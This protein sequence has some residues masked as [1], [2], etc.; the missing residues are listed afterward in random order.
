MNRMEGF[1]YL[2]RITRAALQTFVEHN[3]PLAPVLTTGGARDRQDG[4]RSSRQLLPKRRDQRRA[5]ISHL[6][7]TARN[8]PLPRLL[9]AKRKL[10][11]GA[12]DAANRL[13]RRHRTLEVE[14][15][16]SFEIIVSTEEKARKLAS[17]GKGQRDA[18]RA[19]DTPGPRE[20]DRLPT[21]TSSG[22]GG[23]GMP[24]PLRPRGQCA[25]GTDHGGRFGGRRVRCSSRA[26]RKASRSIRIKLPRF[27][28]NVSNMAGGVPDIAYYH[29]YWKLA[30]DEALVIDATPPECEH[31]NFQLNNYWMESLDY[32]YYPNSREQAHGEVQAGRLGSG[33]GRRGEQKLRQ[34]D[35]YR[36]PRRG[37]DV[38]A[39]GAGERES[40]APD[41]CREA[42]RALM[43]ARV[44]EV[45]RR[46]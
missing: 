37:N 6:G 15:D 19:P 44:A 7:G 5:R 24:T 36:R 9:H 29:S 11:P 8:C 17:H 4:R 38:L 30:P 39:L 32:R 46:M 34:L 21:S 28:Q 35:R 33:C 40:R 41:T 2:S 1:R 23:N 31:W 26:G 3:D 14:P 25:D 42:I 27:D 45:V 12:G 43:T 22:I 18:D 16:G 13:P 10:R 20:R